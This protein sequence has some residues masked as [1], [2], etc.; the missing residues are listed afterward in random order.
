VWKSV[1]PISFC[2]AELECFDFSSSKIC[3]TMHQW[4]PVTRTGE[5]QLS[6]MLTAVLG[7]RG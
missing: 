6:W 7:Q 4:Y 5:K 3:C 2:W 1:E